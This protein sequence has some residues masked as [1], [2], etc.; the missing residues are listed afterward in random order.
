MSLDTEFQTDSKTLVTKRVPFPLRTGP[1]KSRCNWYIASIRVRL[2]HNYRTNTPRSNLVSWHPKNKWQ[3]VSCTHTQALGWSAWLFG[4]ETNDSQCPAR[5]LTQAPGLPVC[6]F[7]HETDLLIQL[8]A[9]RNFR[10]LTT[11]NRITGSFVTVHFYGS[12]L[13]KNTQKPMQ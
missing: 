11:R 9:D 13:R 3:S 2:N 4:H 5:T 12:A 8:I 10:E 1:Q 6:L 7:A